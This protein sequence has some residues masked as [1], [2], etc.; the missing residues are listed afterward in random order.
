[1]SLDYRIRPEARDDI[2]DAYAWYERFD[3]GH[4]DRFLT[5][6]YETLAAVR[7]DP[8]LYG[9]V[10]EPVRAAQFPAMNY[11]LYFFVESECVQVVAVLHAKADPRR[12]QQRQ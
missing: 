6:L 4:G 11:V 7:A 12:W 1:M 2:D 5:E 10:S 3:A 8:E 9:F